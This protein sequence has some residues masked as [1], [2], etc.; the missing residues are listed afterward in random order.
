MYCIVYIIISKCIVV[1]DSSSSFFGGYEVMVPYRLVYNLN[2]TVIEVLIF[3][4]RRRRR[5]LLFFVV[6]DYIFQ[7][8]RRRKIWNFSHLIIIYLIG[9]LRIVIK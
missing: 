7:R 6:D 8:R 5:I 2:N 9:L 1:F 3:K 4:L